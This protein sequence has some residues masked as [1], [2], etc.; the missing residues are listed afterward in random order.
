MVQAMLWKSQEAIS[1][2]GLDHIHR[3]CGQSESDSCLA[4]HYLIK[5]LPRFVLFQR[6]C[7]R[8]EAR[9]HFL[10]LGSIFDIILRKQLF[11][12]GD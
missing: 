2:G 5:E 11:R 7:E 9:L 4:A 1:V 8:R 12:L 6:P 3:F 10:S